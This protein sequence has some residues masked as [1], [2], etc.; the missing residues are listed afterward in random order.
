MNSA[1]AI[2]LRREQRDALYSY[3]LD[4]L[5]GVRDLR[6]AA[7]RGDIGTANRIGREYA[8]DLRLILDDLGWG[9]GGEETV[10]LRNTPPED[11]RRT[12]LRVREDAERRLA[13]EASEH[14]EA[15][16][17]QDEARLL[18]ETCDEG[19]AALDAANRGP[20]ISSTTPQ[21]PRR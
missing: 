16:R 19:L 15:Q 6:M 13:S 5:S 9:D 3:L 7:E 1:P 12:F 21:M 11:L 8:D 2:V 10:A 20:K 14:A 17:F 4:H 18:I